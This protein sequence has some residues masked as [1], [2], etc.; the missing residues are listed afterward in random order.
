MDRRLYIVVSLSAA[1]HVAVV[2]GGSAVTPPAYDVP[3][4]PMSV[5]VTFT[6]PPKQPRQAEQQPRPPQPPLPRPERIDP[7]PAA[8]APS[9]RIA[10]DLPPDAP[11]TDRASLLSAAPPPPARPISP[12]AD[13]G[14][15]GPFEPTA[16]AVPEPVEL[17]P[18]SPPT[19]ES[20]ASQGA[21]SSNPPRP[22]PRNRPPAYPPQAVE[23]RQQGV[24]HL[25]VQVRADGR[26]GSVALA[27]SCGF[28]A[29]DRAAI[30][31]VERWRFAPATRG[32]RPI[33]Y[34]V[35]QPI[36][37]ELRR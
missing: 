2:V 24:V 33:A 8:D 5:A 28:E 30:I 21:Q 23:Q 36:A 27:Q 15:P 22:L 4:T 6:A 32:G 14:A 37:F 9:F 35:E 12:P 25:R 29:L 17:E 34:T 11:T 7:T 3:R 18:L 31:A 13:P 1:L 26:V 10:P 16:W 20:V 19:P